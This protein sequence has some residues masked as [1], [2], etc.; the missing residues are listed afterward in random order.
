M[1]VLLQ[2]LNLLHDFRVE[3]PKGYTHH[4]HQSILKENDV[5]LDLGNKKNVKEIPSHLSNNQILQKN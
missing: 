3:S 1:N 2:P 4:L 5:I